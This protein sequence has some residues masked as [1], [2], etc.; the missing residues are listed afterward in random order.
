MAILSLATA[1]KSPHQCLSFF[2]GNGLVI[3]LDW[4]IEDGLCGASTA[5]A[6]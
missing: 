2:A 6:I 5:C 3:S 4:L 1:G